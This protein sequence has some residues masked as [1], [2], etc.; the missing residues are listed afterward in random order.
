MNNEHPLA[1]VLNNYQSQVYFFVFF[2][3]KTYSPSIWG[4][5]A[6][7]DLT[8]FPTAYFFRGSHGGG[9]IPPPME[10]PLWSV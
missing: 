6:V 10:N 3:L 4:R 7:F 1:F 8:Q 9:G 2:C 5:G